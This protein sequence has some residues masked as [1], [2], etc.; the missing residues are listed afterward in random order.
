LPP[1]YPLP[2]NAPPLS[3]LF[4]LTNQV[5]GNEFLT[6]A[7]KREIREEFGAEV[8]MKVLLITLFNFDYS[9]EEHGL[10]RVLFACGH[11]SVI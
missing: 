2:S 5:E 7:F 8:D 4:S 1:I 6:V 11:S 10:P 3:I 9:V